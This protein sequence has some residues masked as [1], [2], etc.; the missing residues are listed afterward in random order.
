MRRGMSAE[1]ARYAARRDF[2]GV[3]QTK[4][5]HR[6][7][8]GLPFLDTLWQDLRFASRIFAKK[9]GFTAIAVVTL[10]LGIGANTAIF[11][12]VHSVLIQALPYPQADRLA[13]VWSIFSNEGRGPA[14]G[15][16]LVSLRERSR[17]IEEFGGIWAQSGA[18]T[19]EGEP[20]HVRLGLVTSNFLSMLGEHPF[21]GRDFD[22]SEGKP[23][24]AAVALLSYRLWQSHFARDQ[25]LES[26]LGERRLSASIEL[27]RN[28][29]ELVD[30]RYVEQKNPLGLAHAIS[31]ARPLLGDEPFAV[32]L[33]AVIMVNGEPVISQLMRVREQHGGSVVAV[34]EVEAHDVGRFGI[35]RTERSTMLPSGNSIPLIGLVEKPAPDKAP[36]RWVPSAATYWNPSSGLPS[37]KPKLTQAEKCNSQVRS[38]CFAGMRL[39][40]VFASKACTTMLATASVTS[41]LTS[42][43]PSRV[44]NSASLYYNTCLP[45]SPKSA[46]EP[47]RHHPKI[48]TPHS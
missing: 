30:L 17:L 45:F 1:E 24:A 41:R 36:S 27:M 23:G 25:E 16:E 37:A 13:V 44:L 46:I 39:C 43:S 11:T 10:A 38:T 47:V 14:S 32:L 21:L 7:Q 35:V 40:L 33:P 12:V 4:E 3:E 9:P 28:L 18:L 31:C 26:F 19:G 15:P 42:N 2:G 20:E 29:A 22:A 6:E 5:A 48:S 8:R 34:R